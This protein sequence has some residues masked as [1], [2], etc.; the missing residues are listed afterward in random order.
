[1]SKYGRKDVLVYNGPLV[2]STD[3]AIIKKYAAINGRQVRIDRVLLRSQ[4]AYG[5]VYIIE[6][7]DGH[8][9]PPSPTPRPEYTASEE[10]LTPYLEVQM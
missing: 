9:F 10:E 2:H 7:A 5:T 4:G 3:N 1:M 8:P 6:P